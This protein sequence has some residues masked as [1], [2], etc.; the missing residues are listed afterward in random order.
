MSDEGAVLRNWAGN[1]AFSP[2]AVARPSTIDE[3]AET[4]AA[5]RRVRVLGTG[6]SFSPVAD[7]EGTLVLLD[8]MPRTI[9]VDP[10]T[11]TV[12]VAAGVRWGELAPV[13]HEHGF[14]LANMGS[15]PHISV[16]GSASTGT[17][18]SGSRLGCL[19]TSVV[20]LTL[21]TAD[22]SLRE[23]RADDPDLAGSV[24]ALGTLG[25]VTSLELRLVPAFDVAQTVWDGLPLSVA[26]ERF[27]EVMGAAYSVSL[28]TTWRSD[29]VEQVW[30]K[31]RT[32]DPEVDLSWTGAVPADGPRHPV[33]GADTAACTEQGGAAGPWFERLP[34]FRLDFTPSSGSELQTEYMLPREHAAA[35]IEA[36]HGIA[37]VVSPVLQIS[38]IR[39]VAADDLWL[40]PC[41]GRET[42]CVHFTWID[43]ADAVAPAVR[44]VEEAL[45]PYAARPHW[46]K[47]FTTDP[48]LVR[49]H[50]PRLADAE[51]LRDRLDPERRFSNAFVDRYLR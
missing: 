41:Q 40:S 47:V 3:L 19:A 39:T 8:A 25:V 35:A 9:E 45:A 13:V 38:E 31:R 24:V 5:A 1:V 44:A 34:H 22:G 2:A 12:R 28:F 33:P 21:V 49:S 17:H 50:Y 11:A 7:T 27:D 42:V 20:A 29:V 30:V 16:A 32:T 43:D 51:A 18:G 6:H 37:H 15:L 14:A 36:V 10:S 46:G 23:V 48:E 26:A 4:V